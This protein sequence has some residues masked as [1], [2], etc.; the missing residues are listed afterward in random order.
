MVVNTQSSTIPSINQMHCKFETVMLFCKWLLL[1]FETT[2]FVHLRPSRSYLAILCLSAI[3]HT[4]FVH[5]RPSRSCRF[6]SSACINAGTSDSGWS[7]GQFELLFFYDFTPCPPR[8]RVTYVNWDVE[9]VVFVP[10]L[11][12]QVSGESFLSCNS[13]RAGNTTW[14]EYWRCGCVCFFRFFIKSSS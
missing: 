6:Y 5:L 7:A 3:T 12:H 9:T 4:C 8:L 1:S 13:S 10:L 11:S 2:C 14:R